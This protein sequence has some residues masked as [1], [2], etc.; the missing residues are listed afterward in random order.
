M[1]SDCIPGLRKQRDDA[2]KSLVKEREKIKNQRA[3]VEIN[4]SGC[5]ALLARA[6]KAE[7]ALEAA[8]HVISC[9][10][11]EITF[12]R[13]QGNDPVPYE[14][15]LELGFPRGLKYLHPGQKSPTASDPY[16]ALD[17]SEGCGIG[18]GA[19]KG[20]RFLDESK[21]KP[22]AT[23]VCTH[24]TEHGGTCKS[25][26]DKSSDNNEVDPEWRFTETLDLDSQRSNPRALGALRSA[27]DFARVREFIKLAKTEMDRTHGSW[28]VVREHLDGI[29]S[30][31]AAGEGRDV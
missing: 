20:R 9:Y 4:A 8:K 6:E 13:S 31:L 27:E 15:A 29:L 3:T 23:K 1:E 12:L 22:L 5:A 17:E 16:D 30:I 21:S 24:V 11:D 18:R 2:K 19:M 14:L 28:T 10:T 26:K 7:G 25:C